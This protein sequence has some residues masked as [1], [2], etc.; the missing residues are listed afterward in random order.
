MFL[1]NHIGCCLKTKR[2]LNIQ[3]YGDVRDENSGLDIGNS[4]FSE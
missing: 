2:L 3:G 4:G 1:K